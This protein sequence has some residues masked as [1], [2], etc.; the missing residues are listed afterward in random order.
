MYILVAG[1]PGSKWSSVVKNIYW[2]ED[3]D[4]T[5]YSEKRT[6]W[7]DADTPG[8]KQL[9]HTGAYFDPGM[10]FDNGRDNW[11]RPFSGTGHRIIK[12]HTFAHQL[13]ELKTL[14]YPIV[15]VYRSHLEC[16]DWWMQAGGFG[17]TYPNYRDYYKDPENMWTEIKRQNVDIKIFI[18][19]NIERITCPMDN[20]QLCDELGIK[21]PGPRDSIHT[22]NY[23][24]K[25]IKVYVYK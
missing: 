4:H 7:H 18:Q 11:D 16:Y 13:D 9:M 25:D 1:A 17:I 5:D 22:H 10:E 19:K 8:T 3:I 21:S 12:S 15:L 2:S 24:D 6:Y 20:F 23:A 14:G